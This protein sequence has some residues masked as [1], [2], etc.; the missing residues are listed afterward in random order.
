MILVVFRNKAKNL[1]IRLLLAD[2]Y[3]PKTF[4]TEKTK[5][6]KKGIKRNKKCP[7]GG[8]VFS[9]NFSSVSLPPIV[10]RWELRIRE[11]K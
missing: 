9:S 7:E 1:E 2:P 6:N 11:T 4:N 3:W 8:E 10:Q 5:N